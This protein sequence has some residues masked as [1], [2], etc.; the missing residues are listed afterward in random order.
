[1]QAN[2][3]DKYVVVHSFER[4]VR[5]GGGDEGAVP[6]TETWVASGDHSGAGGGDGEGKQAQLEMN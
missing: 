1:L 2:K 5:W 3:Y 6:E 4:V